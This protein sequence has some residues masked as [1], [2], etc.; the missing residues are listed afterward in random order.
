MENL[1][2]NLKF[3][4]S[5]RNSFGF[6]IVYLTEKC[7][8]K[9]F[10][11]L[12]LK[13]PYLL[14]HDYI[15]LAEDFSWSIKARSDFDYIARPNYEHE[16]TPYFTCTGV[17]ID[18]GAH[19]GKWSLYLSRTASKVLSFEPN[20]DTFKYLEKNIAINNI[21]N[22]TPFQMAVSSSN[23]TVK[24]AAEEEATGDSKIAKEGI[25]VRTVTLDTIT[26]DIPSIELIKIDTQAHEMAVLSGAAT[27]LKKTDRVICEIWEKSELEIEEIFVY[28][29]SFGFIPQ[30]LPTKIDYL[31]TKT[32]EL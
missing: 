13:P 4:F 32:K 18:I 5:L 14:R 27:T 7:I 19:M 23:G 1:R 6:K 20:P 24:F 29:K 11:R 8:G 2:N 10:I 17:F 9:I 26:K 22:I 21:K 25:D 12:H 30:Q 15:L 31:F 3:I 16:L 28:M